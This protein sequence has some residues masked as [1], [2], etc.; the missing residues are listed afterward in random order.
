V[1]G[2]VSVLARLKGERGGSGAIE[3]GGVGGVGGVGARRCIAAVGR[4]DQRRGVD[5]SG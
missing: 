5:G 3:G 2:G 1:N 4:V